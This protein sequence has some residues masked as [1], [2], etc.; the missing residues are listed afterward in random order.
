MFLFLIL[1]IYRLQQQRQ[2]QIQQ[3]QQQ[4]QRQ[5][6]QF[7]RSP[8][9][10]SSETSSMQH[11]QQKVP[12]VKLNI[13]VNQLEMS[14]QNQSNAF[15]TSNTMVNNIVTNSFTSNPSAPNAV[16][17]TNTVSNELTNSG[18]GSN[19]EPEFISD[20][21]CA[22]QSQLGDHLQP[23]L[24]IFKQDTN[25]NAIEV[26]LPTNDLSIESAVSVAS[27]PNAKNIMQRRKSFAAGHESNVQA[28]QRQPTHRVQTNGTFIPLN[29]S[30]DTTKQILVQN[31]NQQNIAGNTSSF[32][33]L[34]ARRKSIS[35]F[36]S[37]PSPGQYIAA[38]SPSTT[39]HWRNQANGSKNAGAGRC[40]PTQNIFNSVT[41]RILTPSNQQQSAS[42]SINTQTSIESHIKNISP[43]LNNNVSMTQSGAQ[44]QH[45]Q[46]DSSSFKKIAA[47][48]KSIAVLSIPQLNLNSQDAADT[49]NFN[50]K[51]TNQT[52]KN[53]SFKRIA[54][55]RQ[56]IAACA[57]P[58]MPSMPSLSP[59]PPLLSPIT[60]SSELFNI[61]YA[62]PTIENNPNKTQPIV[63]V[64]L[65]F[66]DTA[67]KQNPTSTKQNTLM[68]KIPKADLPEEI[69]KIIDKFDNNIKPN[70]NQ[71]I[72][73]SDQLSNVIA[74]K[75][76]VKLLTN[77][78]NDAQQ[79][80][81][82]TSRSPIIT[83]NEH[84]RAFIIKKNTITEN[85]KTQS[86]EVKE[87]SE[88]PKITDCDQNVKASN[89]VVVK[90]N[91]SSSEISKSPQSSINI[92]NSS[93]ENN[94]KDRNPNENKSNSTAETLLPA[95]TQ[96]NLNS[97][98]TAKQSSQS[99][100]VNLESNVNAKKLVAENLS[101]VKHTQSSSSPK[102]ESTVQTAPKSKEPAQKTVS[103]F[104]MC[105][106]NKASSGDF[107]SNKAVVSTSPSKSNENTKNTPPNIQEI[108][109]LMESKE[110]NDLKKDNKLS[111]DQNS[112]GPSAQ[113]SKSSFVHPTQ[114]NVATKEST[115]ND[116]TQIKLGIP[117]KTGQ[118]SNVKQC[119]DKPNQNAAVGNMSSPHNDPQKRNLSV[120]MKAEGLSNASLL[121]QKTSTL[122]SQANH[123]K[124]ITMKSPASSR[125]QRMDSV[126]PAVKTLPSR[127][128]SASSRASSALA[129]SAS[130]SSAGST[131][132]KSTSSASISSPSTSS[133]PSSLASIVPM[134]SPSKIVSKQLNKPEPIASN[135][136]I[137]LSD[138]DDDCQIIEDAPI[139]IISIDCDPP[140]L[141]WE[142][143][144]C[145]S[146]VK[147]NDNKN[148][149]MEKVVDQNSNSMNDIS[150]TV[151]K[152]NTKSAMDVSI[153]ILL[154]Y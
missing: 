15:F 99:K 151:T 71:N 111:S 83:S 47:R 81:A 135:E 19:D 70:L 124:A 23:Y 96:Q 107:K 28:I 153:T 63:N 115:L 106:Q 100:H 95:K 2:Q 32:K 69:D 22:T 116:I 112:A 89:D 120:V 66:D 128:A 45:P 40:N 62:A 109:R 61:S 60:P 50:S 93:N 150:V 140:S 136:T 114:K 29:P 77:T 59:P 68:V 36:P 8:E 7:G 65:N 14:N 138:D 12:P 86:Y 78:P 117:V 85:S 110:Q 126:L 33:Q 101:E 1:D 18:S 67:N 122:S 134:S 48:R 147:L 139:E 58:S 133:A 37:I 42:K 87:K 20:T 34:A 41:Q 79:S 131:S 6:N 84:I 75:N 5:S 97:M 98:S 49:G 39:I 90:T 94:S 52:A 13:P 11:Q 129:S 146:P 88:S 72:L 108:A 46:N 35:G 118:S 26:T 137:E 142:L 125:S 73:Q 16:I 92:Q 21:F 10:Q 105:S 74:N 53:A 27:A 4:P 149:M 104:K 145:E 30:L 38:N 113:E 55:R 121:R 57:M 132:S 56:S 64:I 17:C 103:N 80:V 25:G 144:R 3:Q 143:Q 123:N 82:T 24:E 127:N 76:E 31:N 130:T 141:N 9:H 91:D 154:S 102:N 152:T 54:K 148:I 51:N 43:S 44:S 119:I